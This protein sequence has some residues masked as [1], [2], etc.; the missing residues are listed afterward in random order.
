[1]IP[2]IAT[3]H[4]GIQSGEVTNHHDQSLTMPISANFKNRNTM[5]TKPGSPTAAV[6]DDFSL[7][8]QLPPC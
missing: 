4:A 2:A 6:L 1:M 8:L 3:I 7:M 5:N